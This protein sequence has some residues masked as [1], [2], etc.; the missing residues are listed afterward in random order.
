MAPGCF[1]LQLA[2]DLP[3]APAGH[4]VQ[5][6]QL[7]LTGR[8]PGTTGE[9]GG[10]QAAANGE[11]AEEQHGLQGF[12]VGRAGDALRVECVQQGGASSSLTFDASS[13]RLASWVVAAGADDP[14]RELLAAPL[15]PCFYRAPTDNDKG[16]SG[17][18][19]YAARWAGGKGSLPAGRAVGRHAQS[20]Q[21]GA[22]ARCCELQLM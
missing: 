5:A 15:A 19:S 21:E 22:V 14:G 3:W 2:R 1:L 10:G 13:G 17:G 12:A 8:L 7:E 20:K 4:E 6:V 11:Q 18:T 16:G 9:Q